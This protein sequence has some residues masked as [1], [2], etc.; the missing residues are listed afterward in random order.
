MPINK[1]LIDAGAG[2]RFTGGTIAQATAVLHTN[3]YVYLRGG[4]AGLVVSNGDGGTNF[5]L[6]NTFSAWEL[7]NSEKMRLNSTGLGIG[8]N[9]PAAKFNVQGSGTIGWGNLGNALVL[10]GTTS[11]GI[12]IDAN[13]IAGKGDNLY[14]GTIQN[15]SI[16]IRT[17]GANERMRI[18][19]TG[20][21]G[22]ANTSPAYKLDVGGEVKSDGYRIDLSATTQRAITSTGTDSIQFGDAGVNEF[23][24]K[25]VA[26]TSMIINSSGRV[27]IGTSSPAAL[28]DVTASSAPVFR[29]YRSGTGQVW[30]QE[31]DSSGRWEQNIQD[32]K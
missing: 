12:G 4:S 8:T 2:I 32:F 28:L 6:D 31:I 27:G 11:Y 25:N 19:N 17:N 29:L 13:E 21:V 10:A 18:T 5:R 20:N 3:N 14:F 16:I 24:F 23:K 30:T 26:G 1:S 15:H 7:S 9:S 22:I